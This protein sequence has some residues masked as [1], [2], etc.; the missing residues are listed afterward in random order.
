METHAPHATHALQTTIPTAG[1]HGTRP[2]GHP[3][4]ASYEAPP[5]N[6]D[7]LLEPPAGDELDGD[8]LEALERAAIAALPPEARAELGALE[9]RSREHERAASAFNTRRTYRSR[10]A[11]FVEWCTLRGLSS[12]PAHPDVVRLYLVSL[13]R[14][15]L[16][17]STIEVSMAAVRKA[18]AAA[19][20]EAPRSERLAQALAGLR[21]ILGPRATQAHAIG[22]EEVRGMVRA[23]GQDPLGV[24]DR[25][26]VLVAFWSA[27][28]RSELAG[29]DL[30]DAQR[31]PEGYVLR[32][33]RSKTDP[34]GH[35]PRTPG[36]PIHRDPELCPVRALDRWLAVRAELAPSSPALFVT[37]QARGRGAS[38]RVYRAGGRLD[39]GDVA[40]RTKARAERAGFD[41]ARMRAHGFRAG[42]ATSTAR[43]GASPKAIQEHLGHDDFSSTLRYIRAGAALGD[44]NPGRALG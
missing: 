21:K 7:E 19:G 10:W 13:E 36:L 30:D 43:K 28:R 25:A 44:D 8:A 41:P 39:G 37:L 12:L 23:C 4:R 14:E 3:S 42:F 11:S 2:G 27:V 38:G 17:L 24:R 16:S 34:T 26:L 31:D 1:P 40:R 5:P 15:G 29:F 22:L 32:V 33:A 18:H 20:V 6:R 9:A 35:R